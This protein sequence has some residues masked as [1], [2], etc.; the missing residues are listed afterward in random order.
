MY[1]SNPRG[2]GI[3]IA[4]EIHGQLPIWI[5]EHLLEN[6]PQSHSWC[7]SRKH[8][9]ILRETHVHQMLHIIHSCLPWGSISSGNPDSP[10]EADY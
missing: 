8:A 10:K 2:S 4:P 3:Y 5:E 9:Y 6:P 7:L 1:I